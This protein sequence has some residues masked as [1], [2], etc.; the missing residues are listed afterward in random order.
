[1]ETRASMFLGRAED[2]LDSRKPIPS[3]TG[4]DGNIGVEISFDWK[5]RGRGRY[6]TSNA[7]DVSWVFLGRGNLERVGVRCS[8]IGFSIFQHRR[9]GCVLINKGRKGEKK[10]EK[11]W[12]EKMGRRR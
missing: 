4:I 3:K 10:E 6:S 5:S 8:S 11:S 9:I 2:L 1:M 12:E 7:G